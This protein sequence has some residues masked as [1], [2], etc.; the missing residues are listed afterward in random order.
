LGLNAFH[1]ETTDQNRNFDTRDIGLRTSLGFPISEFGRL[2]T[3]AGLEQNE[4]SGLD[5][6]SSSPILF[7]EQGER[8]LS[9]VGLQ[10][11]YDTRNGGLD[12][13]RGVRLQ[14]GLE[15]AGLGGDTEYLRASFLG[16]AEQQ[17]LREDVTLRASF[18]GGALEMLSGSSRL[19]DRFFLSSRQMRGFDA[20]GLGPRD[21][22]ATNQ[23]ALGGNVFTVARFEAAF[24][25]GLP[26]E[27]GISGGVFY[28]IGSVW[29]LDN[30]V[31]AGGALVD[32]SQ[33]FRSSIGVSIFWNTAI[34]PLRFNFSRALEFES[35]DRTR[36]FDLTV[37]TRF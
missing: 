2:N 23:D 14:F 18:E 34:G 15:Y 13:T 8:V 28:D 25:L 6:A 11:A 31:G 4:I 12:P 21:T 10:Y 33:Q 35:Y 17:V 29:G 37:E 5:A 9:F 3:Y 7:A 16:I 26:D 30:K 32:D 22:G 24:P 36:D 20:F 19:S 1:T 27:Y